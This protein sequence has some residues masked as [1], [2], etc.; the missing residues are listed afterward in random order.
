MRRRVGHNLSCRSF[1]VDRRR[2]GRWKKWE[3]RRCCGI[4]KRGGKVLLLDFS[5]ERLLPPTPSPTISALR[6]KPFDTKLSRDLSQTR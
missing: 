3:S 1:K 2:R 4:S 6:A 5:S